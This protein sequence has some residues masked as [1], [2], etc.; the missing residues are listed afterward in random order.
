MNSLERASALLLAALMAS[1]TL[2]GCS[3]APVIELELGKLEILQG[4]KQVTAVTVSPGVEY[5][6]KV[7][8]VLGRDHNFW[9]GRKED[10]AAQD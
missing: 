7:S 5:V 6:F 4:G 2:T 3:S 1:A 10:L 8:N 9:I